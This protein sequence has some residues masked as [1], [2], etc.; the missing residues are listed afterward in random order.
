MNKGTA[1]FTSGR[2]GRVVGLALV[3]GAIALGLSSQQETRAAGQP[4]GAVAVLRTVAGENAGVVAFAPRGEQVLVHATVWGLSPG[5]HG[6]HIHAVGACDP[7]MNFTSAGGHL[8][9]EGDAHNDHAGDQPSLLVLA[10]GT[11]QL[12]FLTDRYTIAD[13]VDADGATVIVHALADNFAHI[14]ERYASDGP[15]AMTLATG[16]AGARIACGLVTGPAP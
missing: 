6:F 13:L 9:P 5:F 4:G 8:N 12:S 15:D 1:W 10:D 7:A 2:A 16:D 14:P 11:G 3:V